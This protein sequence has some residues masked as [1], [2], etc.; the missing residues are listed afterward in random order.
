MGG[1]RRLGCRTVGYAPGSPHRGRYPARTPLRKTMIRAAVCVGTEPMNIQALLGSAFDVVIADEVPMAEA[2]AGGLSGDVGDAVRVLDDAGEKP[3]RV[4]GVEGGG[5]VVVGD[6][7]AVCVAGDGV[8]IADMDVVEE[9]G[10]EPDD[11]GGGADPIGDAERALGEMS[12][13]Q[14]AYRET[15]KRVIG[16]FTDKKNPGPGDL[17]PG[18]RKE[19][20]AALKK[21][22]AKSKANTKNKG[23]SEGGVDERMLRRILAPEELAEI[24]RRVRGGKFSDTDENVVRVAVEVA[25]A[26]MS[27][28]AQVEHNLGAT[29]LKFLGGDRRAAQRV[30]QRA[31][32]VLGRALAD[33]SAKMAMLSSVGGDD[34]A[35][36]AVFWGAVAGDAD[37]SAHDADRVD[38]ALGRDDLDGAMDAVFQ[39]QNRAVASLSESIPKVDDSD[40][41]AAAAL[42]ESPESRPL[43]LVARDNLSR[44]ASD[45][46]YSPDVAEAVF[47]CIARRDAPD[48]GERA[49]YATANGLREMFEADGG[50]VDEGS[51]GLKA[52]LIVGKPNTGGAGA[53]KTAAVVGVFD[54]RSGAADFFKRYKNAY[55]RKFLT[56]SVWEGPLGGGRFYVQVVSKDPVDTV[57]KNVTA[58]SKKLGL[59]PVRFAK[60]KVAESGGMDGVGFEPNDSIDEYRR[61]TAGKRAKV[62]RARHRVTGEKR[63]RNRARRIFYRQHRNKIKRQKKKWMRRTAARRRSFNA[64]VEL[65]TFV[66]PP[67][68]DGVAERLAR[69]ICEMARQLGGDPDVESVGGETVV[70][71]PADV[72]D[73]IVAFCESDDPDADL[74]DRVAWQGLREHDPD[75]DALPGVDSAADVVAVGSGADEAKWS[76][77]VETKWEPP[78]GMFKRGAGAI[79]KALAAQSGSY[80][81][82][83]SRLNFYANRAGSNLSSER[84]AT[85]EKAKAILRKAYSVKES[86]EGADGFAIDATAGP[87]GDGGPAP[88][89]P[90]PLT[91]ATVKDNGSSGTYSVRVSPEEIARWYTTRWG[92]WRSNKVPERAF[93]AYFSKG[94]GDYEPGDFVRAAPEQRVFIESPPYQQLVRDMGYFGAAK[95]GLRDARDNAVRKFGAIS[96]Y[97]KLLKASADLGDTDGPLDESKAKDLGAYFSVTVG[98]RDVSAWKQRWPASGLPDRAITFQFDKRSGD[99]V[100][101]YPSGIDGE[102]AAALSRD[103]AYVGAKKLG[104][105]GIVAFLKP[106]ADMRSARL[107]ESADVNDTDGPLD[108]IRYGGVRV[109]PTKKY[110]VFDVVASFESMRDA[111]KLMQYMGTIIPTGKSPVLRASPMSLSP[112]KVVLSIRAASANLATDIARKVV[113]KIGVVA[114]SIG[115]ESADVSEG[116]PIGERAYGGA[117]LLP[118]K[119]F[120]LFDVTV[121]FES[122]GDSTALMHYMG[123][124][125]P[126]GKSPVLRAAPPPLS[127]RKVVLSIRAASASLAVDIARK[128][129]RKIG[130]VAESIGVE[131]GADGMGEAAPAS[132]AVPYPSDDEL[133][134]IP[135]ATGGALGELKALLDRSVATPQSVDETLDYTLLLLWGGVYWLGTNVIG[136]YVLRG[137][138]DDPDFGTAAYYY[139]GTDNPDMP[140]LAFDVAKRRWIV[141]VPR[142]LRAR[143]DVNLAAHANESVHRFGDL[144]HLRIPDSERFRVDRGIFRMVRV[145]GNIESREVDSYMYT[146]GDGTYFIEIDTTEGGETNGEW[147]YLVKR[148]PM[149]PV[150]PSP[151]TEAHKK[152]EK[153]YGLHRPDPSKIHTKD[154]MRRVGSAHEDAIGEPVSVLEASL[155]RL[156]SG[157][158]SGDGFVLLS[159]SRAANWDDMARLGTEEALRVFNRRN[160]AKTTEMS[161][162][163]SSLGLPFSRVIGHYV[164]NADD[165]DKSKHIPV[166]E[167]S[168]FVRG[169]TADEAREL[170]HI[171]LKGFG[172][173]G[174]LYGRFDEAGKGSAF[175]VHGRTGRFE[176]VGSSL[177]ARD[178]GAYFTQAKWSDFRKGTKRP[179]LQ[180]ECCETIEGGC[181]VCGGDL[182]PLGRLGNREHFKC[183]HCGMMASKKR[184]GRGGTLGKPKGKAAR[185]KK[186][187]SV[188]EAYRAM[189]GRVKC[190]SC[191]EMTPKGAAYQGSARGKRL[192]H[193]PG[194][195][196]RFSRDASGAKRTIG[197]VGER[198]V[199]EYQGDEVYPTIRDIAAVYG[200]TT[201]F[202]GTGGEVGFRTDAGY[203]WWAWDKDQTG[204]VRAGKSDGIGVNV[205]T[206][207]LTDPDYHEAV[208]VR[209]PESVA[210]LFGSVAGQVGVVRV[211][212]TSVRDG[213]YEVEMSRDDA[214]RMRT[215]FSGDGIEYAGVARVARGLVDRD[216]L[217]RSGCV[218]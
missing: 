154:L 107:I 3:T 51:D 149:G 147:Y 213:L 167:R 190:P 118:P 25:W 206:M 17:E 140:T 78:E 114:E 132:P 16:G 180:F 175:I 183:R 184:L 193:C 203:D 137:F 80:Q 5:A 169:I 194:C 133:G 214:V 13:Q 50:G 53:V 56:G 115:V 48:A 108:E 69:D 83:M 210:P 84:K 38:D 199:R 4:F 104:L 200:A 218:G 43:L 119:K 146:G 151:R 11:G 31:G 28:D 19:F 40:P 20:F 166:T 18:K 54:T 29:L 57:R 101:I 44:L 150:R 157:I 73:A 165:K 215:V 110:T 188:D 65:D 181:P 209:F 35:D 24:L 32:A 26:Q 15:F 47:Y 177:H 39:M 58:L 94:D 66:L 112:R 207:D 144:G 161:R 106:S 6:S 74:L 191:G 79:A 164:E 148:A 72:A 153:H 92:P 196:T 113:R 67:L 195:Q 131:P 189:A 160:N 212:D 141:A 179:G 156:L 99:L 41:E 217:S 23:E 34:V 85:L 134:T 62:A 182:E 204:Y 145:P 126:T 86:T 1:P 102:A 136:V 36:A 8:G 76:A 135:N 68:S 163:L 96:G 98:K 12:A 208:S 139:I 111:T 46:A 82:A 159:A 97:A 168:F 45:G 90:V 201:V 127:P 2:M 192:Y 120:N 121:E 129:V 125:I 116:W 89:V 176:H 155:S 105:S 130:V 22:W 117:R 27:G 174:V 37:A 95:L 52:I 197:G 170:A 75:G 81:Q 123:I 9:L 178:V 128:V 142:L 42:W 10:G 100:D 61:Q 63:K 49:W 88:V 103:A 55:R 198:S 211:G 172:Q 162:A 202:R 185:G 33:R 21:E 143:P 7:L 71:I 124:I 70:A 14:R 152:I 122:V 91:E 93:T 216:N 87:M 138:G 59:G 77:S 171:A 30:V 60:P 186:G 109:L 205:T 158:R 64:S 173:E 187:E